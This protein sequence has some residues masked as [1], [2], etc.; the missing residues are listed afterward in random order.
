V[1]RIEGVDVRCVFVKGS[2]ACGLDVLRSG[3]QPRCGARMLSGRSRSQEHIAHH[4]AACAKKK[5]ACVGFE[6]S[7]FA[8]LLSM[9]VSGALSGTRS[10]IFRGGCQ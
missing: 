3:A 8:L 9:V 5:N 10:G 6:C 2:K 4:L 1:N 7:V